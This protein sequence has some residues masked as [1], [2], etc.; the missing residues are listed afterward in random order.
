MISQVYCSNCHFPFTL[1]KR[2]RVFYKLWITCENRLECRWNIVIIV[3]ATVWEPRFA[4]GKGRE[5][6]AGVLELPPE[7]IPRSIAD[8]ILSTEHIFWDFLQ[9][10]ASNSKQY[11]IS[12]AVRSI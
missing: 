6:I 9:A 5:L 4:T 2:L 8:V 3:L 1:P 7:V 10:I 11:R 12:S